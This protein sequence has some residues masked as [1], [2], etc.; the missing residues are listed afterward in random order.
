V[1]VV[2]DRTPTLQ[3]LSLT[4]DRNGGAMST[5]NTV[6][7]EIIVATGARFL[8]KANVFQQAYIFVLEANLTAQKSPS[9]LSE[10]Q[11]ELENRLQPFSLNCPQYFRSLL[12]LD[13]IAEF[14]L[15]IGDLLKTVIKKNPQKVGNSQFRLSEILTTGSPE[16]LISRAAEELLYKMLY[17]K[18]NEYLQEMCS[19]FSIKTDIIAPYWGSFVEAKARRDLG[20]HNNWICNAIYIRK[21]SEAGI[22]PNNIVGDRLLPTDREYAFQVVTSLA[23]MME[24]LI[25]SILLVHSPE[26]VQQIV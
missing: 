14:E 13:L 16:E 26:K 3:R 18:P 24:S 17:K 19:L 8:E 21:V 22:K 1:G 5:V 25:D 15:S 2:V 7:D 9:D 6:F 20:M 4:K 12:F 10:A 23:K 11:K